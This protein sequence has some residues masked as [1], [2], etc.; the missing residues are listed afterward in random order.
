MAFIALGVGSNISPKL[1][2]RSGI[3][4]LKS[5]LNETV[6]SP[7]YESTSVGFEGDNFYNC[8]VIG[9][10][11]LS[12]H[13]LHKSLKEIEVQHGRAASLA[14]YSSKTLDIDMLTYDNMVGV[15]GSISLP[16]EEI[17]SAAFVLKPLSDVLPN[18]EHP[19]LKQPYQTLWQK[20]KVS[21]EATEQNLWLAPDDLA[22]SKRKSDNKIAA[23]V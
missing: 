22:Q 19:V 23:L 12:L 6:C 3:D 18:A 15:F 13:D 17:L 10:T 5:L 9:K 20:F 21:R 4:A 14:R 8:V 7:V 16:R 1:N 11:N 2:I